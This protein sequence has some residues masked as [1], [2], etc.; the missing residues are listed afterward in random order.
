MSHFARNLTLS[1]VYYASIGIINNFWVPKTF[2]FIIKQYQ[3][4]SPTKVLKNT[5][6]YKY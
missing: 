2:K 5:Y 3:T 6:Y 1:I 4:A